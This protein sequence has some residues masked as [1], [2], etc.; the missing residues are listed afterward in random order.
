MNTEKNNR[1]EFDADEFKT[2][3]GLHHKLHPYN[4]ERFKTFN[5]E[6]TKEMYNFLR[7]NSSEWKILCGVEV[8]MRYPNGWLKEIWYLNCN[9][10]YK[11]GVIYK[12]RFDYD[13]YM[14][15]DW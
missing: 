9:G 4:Y 12:N 5:P 2:K 7:G 6:L 10:S 13:F 8:K 14:G 11:D 3:Y 1:E 15:L